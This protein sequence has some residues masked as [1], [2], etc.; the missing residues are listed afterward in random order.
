MTRSLLIE[1]FNKYCNCLADF[2]PGH[3]TLAQVGCF[4][5]QVVEAFLAIYDVIAAIRDKYPEEGFPAS[6]ATP[7]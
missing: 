5:P 3:I 1:R 7:F 6:L 4:D 2:Y